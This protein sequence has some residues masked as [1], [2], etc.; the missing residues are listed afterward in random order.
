MTQFATL[1]DLGPIEDVVEIVRPGSKEPLKMKLLLVSTK[2]IED[3]R[4][5]HKWPRRKPSG[6][7]LDPSTR[8]MMPY[9]DEEAYREEMNEAY[10]SFMYKIIVHTMMEPAIKG[11]DDDERVENLQIAL[12]GWAL[13]QLVKIVNDRYGIS[14][15]E[16]EATEE[17]LQVPI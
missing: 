9:Y 2:E 16:V 11:E 5:S 17:N 7:R 4:K 8:Q 3:I 1:E 15:Q 14:P 13:P 6:S 10:T 12:G